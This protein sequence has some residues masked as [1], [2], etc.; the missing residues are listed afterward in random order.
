MICTVL[1]RYKLVKV[2][3]FLNHMHIHARQKEQTETRSI[4]AHRLW[5]CE[6]MMHK[7]CAM[8]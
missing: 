7:C 8:L 5:V 4:A 2:Y 3:R 1:R 6:V